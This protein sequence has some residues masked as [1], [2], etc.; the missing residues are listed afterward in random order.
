[1][2]LNCDIGQ[3]TCLPAH[4]IVVGRRDRMLAQRV[5]GTSRPERSQMAA[6]LVGVAKKSMKNWNEN[7]ER[8]FT[9]NA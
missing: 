7:Y 2:E 3:S 1:M 5:T 4:D 6:D 9:P 8:T